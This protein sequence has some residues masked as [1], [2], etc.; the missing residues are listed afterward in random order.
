M[1]LR[2]KVQLG[3]TLI[4][5]VL[6]GCG[7]GE[8]PF[9]LSVRPVETMQHSQRFANS[10]SAGSAAVLI[11][12][13]NEVAW[14][15]AYHVP[16]PVREQPVP[17]ISSSSSTA[18]YGGVTDAAGPWACI[19]EAET[20]TDWSMHGSTYSTAF[21]MVNDIIYDYG[22]PE[23]QA[24]VFSGTA[25][26]ETQIRIASAFANDHGFGGWGELTKQK[27]GL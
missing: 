19:A 26:A 21:G 24:A 11:R 17:V 7:R 3:G 16:E 27:C 10:F 13:A 4:V 1:S 12:R 14:L 15:A 5:L 2:R 23:E 8:P 9:H 25:S 20:G 6:S 22:T 18:Q